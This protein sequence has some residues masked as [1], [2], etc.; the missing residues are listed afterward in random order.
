MSFSPDQLK[1]MQEVFQA[2]FK[3]F[4]IAAMASGGGAEKKTTNKRKL[5]DKQY[6]GPG[7]VWRWRI[8]MEAMGLPVQDRY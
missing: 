1:E 6:Q 7:E 8:S 2:M 5:Y 4:G 3:Q